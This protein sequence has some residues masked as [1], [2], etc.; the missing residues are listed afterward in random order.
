[1]MS[2]RDHQEESGDA[3]MNGQDHDMKVIPLKRSRDGTEQAL[4]SVPPGSDDP[5]ARQA[6]QYLIR[7]KN[8]PEDRGITLRVTK[9]QGRYY[10]TEWRTGAVTFHGGTVDT[11]IARISPVR[12][13][14]D[15]WEL[16]WMMRDLKWH[17]LG[18][19]YRG[20]FER[21]L[22]LIVEDPDCCFWG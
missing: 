20:S 15:Q 22:E 3:P 14:A 5:R 11:P 18:E 12:G 10:V 7:G 8:I 6:E 9:K 16:A 13:M 1:M 21:C 19:D 2:A 4:R 17:N